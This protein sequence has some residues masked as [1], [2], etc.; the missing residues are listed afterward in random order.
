MIEFVDDLGV[1]VFSV[2]V[3]VEGVEGVDRKAVEGPTDERRMGMGR[4]A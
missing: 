1:R 3:A 4:K 2:L